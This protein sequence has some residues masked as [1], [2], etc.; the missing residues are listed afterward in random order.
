MNRARLSYRQ[1]AL[2]TLVGLALSSACVDQGVIDGM[3]F[4]RE[5]SSSQKTSPE[6]EMAGPAEPI[7][8]NAA[9]LDKAAEDIL[10]EF[11]LGLARAFLEQTPEAN[12]V[13]SPLGASLSL[14]LVYP[15]AAGATAESIQNV[16]GMTGLCPTAVL[17][18]FQGVLAR[19]PAAAKGVELELAN[20]IFIQ[21]GLAIA[22]AFIEQ[23][24][25]YNRT[26]VRTVDFTAQQ[27]EADLDRWAA[28]A[29]QGRIQ[30]LAADSFSGDTLLLLLQA[31][32]FKGTWAVAFDPQKTQPGTFY[33]SED[34]TVPMTLM[35][36]RGTFPMTSNDSLQA[37]TLPYGDG[38][39]AM[40]V[41]LPHVSS[42]TA[43]YAAL[44]L[45][46]LRTLRAAMQEEE[47]TVMLPRFAVSTE[48]SLKSV[49]ATL[50]LGGLFDARADLSG[51]VPEGGLSLHDMKQKTVLEVQE[52]GT[53]TAS[54]TATEIKYGFFLASHPFL[55]V[56][57][58]RDTSDILFAG[59]ITRP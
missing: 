17:E 55:F 3:K 40:T 32:S 21:E 19:L 16:L 34:S 29:T 47:T 27:T 59:K 31:I 36:T 25:R 8:T 14:G 33:V 48:T 6:A 12:A 23:N 15:G 39:L 42:L 30:K 4:N 22:P 56:I 45:E 26:E 58:D 38:R 2:G 43:A 50:G 13:L 51:I 20:G 37:V 18:S 57:H 35:R 1:I 54:V 44:T 5:P 7:A 53:A 41:L 24:Q 9:C 49:L 28:Q 11:S 10:G 46:G 52:T